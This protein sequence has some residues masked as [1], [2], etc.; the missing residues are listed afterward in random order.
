MI[1]SAHI[2][3]HIYTYMRMFMSTHMRK[4]IY[5]CIIHEIQHMQIHI[6]FRFSVFDIFSELDLF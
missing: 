1:T 2:E 3:T 5:M 4:N 6:D